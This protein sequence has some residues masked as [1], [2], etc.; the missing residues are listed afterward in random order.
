MDARGMVN[1]NSVNSNVTLSDV[2]KKQA[3]L[4]AKEESSSSEARQH[5][6]KIIAH[7]E[8]SLPKTIRKRAVKRGQ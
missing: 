5:Y 8:E 4:D 6:E 1:E 7:L 2:D 3:E